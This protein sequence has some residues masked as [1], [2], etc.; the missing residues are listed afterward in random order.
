M[1]KRHRAE[2]IVAPLRQADVALG[3]VASKS[4][5]AGVLAKSCRAAFCGAL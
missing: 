2:Q 4:R 3:T 1:K 5:E